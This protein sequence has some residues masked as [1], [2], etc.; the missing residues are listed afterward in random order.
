MK[1]FFQQLESEDEG[2]VLTANLVKTY[3]STVYGVNAIPITI[4]VA[5]SN[6]FR[7]YIVGLP[8]V[9]VRESVHRI[10]TAL[11]SAGLTWPKQRIVVNM[12]PSDLRKEGSAYD[13]TLALAI[14]AAAGSISAELME[15]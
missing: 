3:A 5:A 11:I 6:G 7:T 15:Q 14:L 1:N 12:A 10:K 4:E 13:L 9:A 2:P 8:D